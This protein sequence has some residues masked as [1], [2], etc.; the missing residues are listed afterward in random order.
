MNFWKPLLDCG[1]LMEGGLII[2]SELNLTIT[3]RDIWGDHTRLDPLYT[4]FPNMFTSVGLVVVPPCPNIPTW[5]NGRL[6]T[7]GISK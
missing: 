4:Y 6:G 3:S 7:T 5:Q 1:F 2:G